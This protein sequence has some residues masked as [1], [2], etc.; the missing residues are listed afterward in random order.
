MAAHREAMD[1]MDCEAFLDLGIDAFKWLARA[2]NE[3]RTQEVKGELEFPADEVIHELRQLWLGQSDYAE[4][5]I[6][7]QHERNYKV[8][9][10]DDFRLCCEKMRHAIL[11]EDKMRELAHRVPTMDELG[12]IA[13]SP[14]REW[15]DEPSWSR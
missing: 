10:L 12:S 8:R 1:C 6:A 3:L 11:E 15:T 13:T 5:W 7:V 4:R 2:T 14:P 9:N